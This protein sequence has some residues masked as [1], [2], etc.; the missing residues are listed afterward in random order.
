MLSVCI[1][2]LVL[3]ALASRPSEASDGPEQAVII[4][5]FGNT[6]CSGSPII[7][8]PSSIGLGCV[9]APILGLFVNGQPLSGLN[10]LL[11]NCPANTVSYGAGNCSI[12]ATTTVPAASVCLVQ[13]IASLRFECVPDICKPDDSIRKLQCDDRIAQCAQYRTNM[14]WYKEFASYLLLVY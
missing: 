5:V 12:P 13:S 8:V 3:L 4:E 10:S 11:W 6:D 14:K 7:S 2:V 9:F 1:L